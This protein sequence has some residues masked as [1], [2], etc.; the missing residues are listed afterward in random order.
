MAKLPTSS[1]LAFRRA[2]LAVP[3]ALPL[4]VAGCFDGEPD[5]AEAVD[6]IA[7][8]IRANLPQGES[9]LE[10]LKFV[11]GKKSKDGYDVFV[12]YDLVTTM[13]S[14]GL[15]N[16]LNRPGDR[17]HVAGERYG[18]VSGAKGWTLQ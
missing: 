18:F 1:R 3:F 6:Q 4:L 5:P 17:Q 2:M 9:R 8:H 12:D 10:N 16:A 11:S 15:F 7:R 14:V 13:A